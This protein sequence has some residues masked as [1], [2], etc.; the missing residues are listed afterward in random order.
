L[1]ARRQAKPQTYKPQ[2]QIAPRSYSKNSL[3]DKSSFKLLGV[4]L[5]NVRWVNFRLRP[6]TH[7]LARRSFKL[8]R[9][10][11]FVYRKVRKHSIGKQPP[12]V[13]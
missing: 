2:P 3:N 8:I 1:V 7:L 10:M 11:H 5:A 6:S 9:D 12:V 13:A 4:R